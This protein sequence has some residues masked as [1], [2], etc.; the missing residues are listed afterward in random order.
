MNEQSSGKK[1]MEMLATNRKLLIALISL[2]MGFIIWLLTF[3]FLKH[4]VEDFSVEVADQ[5]NLRADIL[6]DM[7]YAFIGLVGA[8][9]SMYGAANYGEHREKRK[10]AEADVN[11]S[12]T[13]LDLPEPTP[14]EDR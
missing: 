6:V 4:A 7:F 11:N 2:G 10:V 9:L 14:E 8:V 13:N 12:K 5:I 1:F 3:S